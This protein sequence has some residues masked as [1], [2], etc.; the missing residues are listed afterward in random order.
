MCAVIQLRQDD[1]I[2]TLYNLVGFQTNLKFPEHTKTTWLRC[3]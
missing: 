3:C 1:A 2:D